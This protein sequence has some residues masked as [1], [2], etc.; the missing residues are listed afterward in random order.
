MH[1]LGTYGG[2]VENVRDP[3]RLGRA[4]VR[5]PHL[6][7]TS[8][9]SAGYVGVNDLPWAMPAGMPA[10]GSAASGGFSHLPAPGDHVWV[11]F[12]DGEAEKPIWEWGMQTFADRDKLKLHTYETTPTGEVSPPKS[13][14]WTRY[15][16]VV[17]LTDPGINLITAG[18]YRIQFIDGINDGR[19]DLST[20]LGNFLRLDD[21]D[22]G[23][24]MFLNEDWFINIGQALTGQSNT[25]EWI[26]ATDDFSVVSGQAVV[27][28]SAT[29]TSFGAGTVFSVD[30]LESVDFTAPMI[31]LG[32]ETAVQPVILGTQLLTFL[33]SLLVYLST[34]THG[35]GN[36]GSPTS[37][38]IIPPVGVVQP[39]PSTLLSTT[40]FTV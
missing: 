19:I 6:H 23:A 7:G 29:D 32:G 28:E 12:L 4:K 27:F 1:F 10:G 14:Y 20:A 15:N 25:F 5:V 8:S 2:I 36:N 17:E 40:V 16:H 34:H 11:R 35:N 31:R 39:E 18:G 24:T 3:E 33:E 9:A 22:N 37:P 30:A 21:T 26:T 38:P 13:A